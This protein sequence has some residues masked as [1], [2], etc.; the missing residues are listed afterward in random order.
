MIRVG[1]GTVCNV[2][3]GYIDYVL[4]VLGGGFGSAERW[5]V[6]YTCLFI[7]IFTICDYYVFND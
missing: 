7:I 4:A 5:R 1:I 6:V 3:D 2:F